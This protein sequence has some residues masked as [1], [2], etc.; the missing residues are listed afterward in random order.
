MKRAGILLVAL[1]MTLICVFLF[2]VEAASSSGEFFTTEDGKYTYFVKNGE[3]EIRKAYEYLTGRI[4][5]PDTLGGYPVTSIGT[6]SFKYCKRITSVEI[7]EG[8]KKI[9]VSAFAKCT[10][11]SRVIIPDSVESIGGYAFDGCKEITKIALGAGVQTI[12]QYAFYG[13]E[14]VKS[15]TLGDNVKIIEDNAFF[16]TKARSVVVPKGIEKIGYGAFSYGTLEILFHKGTKEEWEQNKLGENLVGLQV[17]HNYYPHDCL[18][19][20]G[21]IT[22]PPTCK[23]SGTKRF[24]CT[25]CGATKT[26]SIPALS[27][28]SYDN[29]VIT[30]DPTCKETGVKTY[31]CNGCGKTKTETVEKGTT[32]TYQNACDT[33]CDICG[34]ERKT[35]HQYDTSWSK[36][37]SGHWHACEVCGAKKDETAHKPGATATET[38]AQKCT[39]CG[40]IIKEALGHTHKYSDAWNKDAQFHWHACS[41]CEQKKD[42]AAHIPGAAATETTAQTC[43]VCG[44]VLAPATGPAPTDPAPTIPESTDPAP[45][46]PMPTEPKPD[47]EPKD[48]TAVVAAVCVAGA[49]AVGGGGALF[50]FKK[51]P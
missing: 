39:E 19:D 35:T 51:K 45:T 49:A 4:V 32:H 2:P 47:G 33:D 24:T 21:V 23:Y 14:D 27:D 37:T 16:G 44:Y 18:Y 13:C 17:V 40:Y 28:H 15:I 46:E 34:A 48:N 1:T 9:G 25:I 8:V 3:A 41:G 43:T 26:E 10:A 5:I 6:G 11:L 7:P 20:D 42:K 30:K 12:G 36:D 50:I 22:S 31:T 38:T 29:G